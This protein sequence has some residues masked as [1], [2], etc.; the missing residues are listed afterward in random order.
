MRQLWS[1]S[2]FADWIRGTTKPTI[3]HYTG[4]EE[5]EAEWDAWI[6]YKSKHKFRCWLAEE[7]LDWI[8]DSIYWPIKKRLDNIRFYIRNRW[9]SKT[10]L[11]SSNLQKGDW[12]EYYSRLLHSAFD[13]YVDFVQGEEAWFHMFGMG[14]AHG[15]CCKYWTAWFRAI[16]RLAQRCSPES[17][18]E[19]RNWAVSLGYHEDIGKEDPDNGTLTDQDLLAEEMVILYRWWKEDRPRRPD[20]QDIL[21]EIADDEEDTEMLVRLVKIRRALWI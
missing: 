15:A 16:S 4:P 20:P 8:Q 11:L 21:G 10:H 17:A 12:H 6:R 7:G 1:Y 18:Q 3:Y 9:I 5:W 14:Y 2:K 13:S 19:Y